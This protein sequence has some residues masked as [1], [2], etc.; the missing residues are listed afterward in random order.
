MKKSKL[1]ITSLLLSGV[2]CLSSCT[3]FNDNDMNFTNTYNPPESSTTPDPDAVI[4]EGVTATDLPSVKDEMT[5]ET[6]NVNSYYFKNIGYAQNGVITN[7]Y[8][9]GGVNHVEYNVNGGE[10][11]QGTRSSNNYD[12]YVP[13][14]LNKAN[15]HTVILFVHGGAWIGGFKTDVNQYV[16]EFASRGYITATVKYTLLKKSMDNASLSIFRDLDELDAC[17]ASIKRALNDL[18][19]DTTK[20]NLVIGGASS[21]AHL[22]ML[23]AY[24]RGHRSPLPIRFIIDAVGP[25]D[26]KPDS[27]KAF[28]D[29]SDEVLEGG[30]TDTAISSQPTNLT[31]LQVSGESY[32]WNEYQT[33]RIANGMCGIPYSL[34]DVEASANEEKTAIAHP[35]AAS[36]S[37]T[38]DDGGEDQL[39]VTYWINK[40]INNYRIICAYAGKDSVVGIAQYARLEKALKDK[41]IQKEFFYFKNA[42][43]MEI[44]K[45]KTNPSYTGFVNQIDAWGQEL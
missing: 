8:K 15:K 34:S 20:T 18:E 25:V 23:Y 16:R 14:T 7:T 35:N 6:Y 36:N 4:A 1:L 3:L 33:M 10:D 2:L 45:D 40:G 21:G 41:G 19:F 30:I 37:M 5:G 11:Y 31:E 32:G 13:K 22:S 24:S 29:S 39:S 27:W 42:D 26:I 38:K 43:H 9:T 17:I 12:L 28:V 44:N